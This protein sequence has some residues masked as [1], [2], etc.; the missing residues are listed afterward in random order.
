MLPLFAEM[1]AIRCGLSSQFCHVKHRYVS[2]QKALLLPRQ[3]NLE[4]Y[5]EEEWEIK[6]KTTKLNMHTKTNQKLITPL[7]VIGKHK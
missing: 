3:N 1:P 6:S 5:F 7:F 2:R 4:D